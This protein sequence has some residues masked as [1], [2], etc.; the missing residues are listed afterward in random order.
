MRVAGTDGNLM[1]T[2]R[3]AQ[4]HAF[5]DDGNLPLA[6]DVLAVQQRQQLRKPVGGEPDRFAGDGVH[7]VERIMPPARIA[8]L[9]HLELLHGRGDL[10]EIVQALHP[11]SALPTGLDGWNQQRRQQGD[12]DHDHHDFHHR[13]AAPRRPRFHNPPPIC[14]EASPGFDPH[15]D[16]TNQ[17]RAGLGARRRL[18]ILPL[19]ETATSSIRPSAAFTSTR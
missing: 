18:S 8:L 17:E 9:L 7:A 3:V 16:S 14:S 2:G 15:Q 5:T 6:I 13:K 12:D 19:A 11:A 1:Q 4:R 10:S